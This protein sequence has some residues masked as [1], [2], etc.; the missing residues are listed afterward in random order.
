MDAGAEHP[1]GGDCPAGVIPVQDL[2][3]LM[4]S[5]AGNN[6]VQTSVA[7]QASGSGVNWGAG[8]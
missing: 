6:L 7:V 2:P 3:V 5:K 1:A 4:D 8:G